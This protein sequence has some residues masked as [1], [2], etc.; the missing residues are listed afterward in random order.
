HSRHGLDAIARQ[1]INAS[2]R[3]GLVRAWC[4]VGLK[5]GEPPYLF[6]STEQGPAQ[7][8]YVNVEDHFRC[9]AESM[10]QERSGHQRGHHQNGSTVG[11]RMIIKYL[12]DPIDQ[13]R[14]AFAIVRCCLWVV[15]PGLKSS[16][17]VDGNVDQRLARP[18]SEVASTKLVDRCGVA[19]KTFRGRLACLFRPTHPGRDATAQPPDLAREQCPR[20]TEYQ[21][22][23]CRRCGVGNNEHPPSHH[24]VP[25]C[26]PLLGSIC[27]A[28][29]RP[30]S[31]ETNS[32][33]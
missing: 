26:L 27:Q 9:R 22:I 2:E 24:S 25:D 21:R 31:R 18:C 11:P 14:E 33:T 8:R 30:T 15:Q 1:L 3:C 20:I 32:A 6:T 4:L 16:R 23:G 28:M 13:L 19:A 12:A 29:V 10:D 17:V 7:R 5:P